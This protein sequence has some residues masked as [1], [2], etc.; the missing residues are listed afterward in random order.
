MAYDCL[1]TLIASL[2]VLRPAFT[3]PGFANLVVVFAGWVLTNGPHAVTEALVTT[4]PV[5]RAAIGHGSR[6]KP[7]DSGAAR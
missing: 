6:Q 4:P 3:R 7:A 2:E 5:L 1:R